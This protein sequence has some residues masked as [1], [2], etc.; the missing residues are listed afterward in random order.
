L[1][2]DRVS[3]W[4][5]I[6]RGWAKRCPH[7]GR[8]GIFE[9]WAKPNRR[10]PRCH[11]LFERD[12]GETWGVWIVT[13]RI[14]LAV[15]ILAVY[16]GFRVTNVWAGLGFLAAMAVPLVWSIPRRHGFA[17]ALVYLGRR[18][19]PNPDDIFPALPDESASD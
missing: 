19:W 14:T 8:G 11:Y 18:T 3:A 12:Y 17:I 2:T 6:R 15:G 7:C 9:R 1:A 13:D 16:F 5:I 10:C 4:E